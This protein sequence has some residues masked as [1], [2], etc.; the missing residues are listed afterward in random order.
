MKAPSRS[1]I[2]RLVHKSEM[3]GSVIKIKRGVVSRKF[4]RTSENIHLLRRHG[5]SPRKYV[6]HLFQHIN[7]RTSST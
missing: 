2:N 1:A 7:L 6:K 3:M 5:H 4:V